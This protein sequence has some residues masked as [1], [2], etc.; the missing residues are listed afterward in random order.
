MSKVEE[1]KELTDGW[2]VE[3]TLKAINK[4]IQGSNKLEERLELLVFKCEVL[5]FSTYG[6]IFTP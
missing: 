3:K 1:L 4:A 6:K 5:E 2:T